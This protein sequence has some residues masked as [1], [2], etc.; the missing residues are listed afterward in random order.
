MLSEAST[1]TPSRLV[2]ETTLLGVTPETVTDY[3]TEPDL[4][5][6]WWADVADIDDD[7]GAYEF[8]WP[9]MERT[10]RGKYTEIAR[11]R[12]IRFTWHWDHEPLHP[13]R[14]VLITTGTV[15]GGTHLTITHGDYAPDDSEERNGHIEGWVH[16]I[17]RLADRI[18]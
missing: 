1:S 5:T 9:A 7:S 11:G 18:A 15:D 4:L 17:D 3:F 8:R 6:T 2:L 10:L 16:F 13:V 14:S 12:R